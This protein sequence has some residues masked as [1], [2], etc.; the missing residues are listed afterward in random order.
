MFLLHPPRSATPL[1]SALSHHALDAALVDEGDA[2]LSMCT[3]RKRWCRVHAESSAAM[4]TTSPTRPRSEQ[5]Q[6]VAR[7]V[8][9][10]RRMEVVQALTEQKELK[11][12][13]MNM[14]RADVRVQSQERR[15]V[16][17][18][19]KRL[20][21]SLAAQ[22]SRQHQLQV[23]E[24][25]NRLAAEENTRILNRSATAQKTRD[26]NLL[27]AVTRLQNRRKF[28]ITR[29]HQAQT[30]MED[31][32]QLT[33]A[34]LQHLT[35]AEALRESRQRSV[36][37]LLARENA[38]HE[39][40]RSPD[41]A[42]LPES[43]AKAP[44]PPLPIPA[45][46]PQSRHRLP[47]STHSPH[48]VDSE[49]RPPP[50]HAS[51]STLIVPAPTTRASSPAQRSRAA[52]PGASSTVPR[53]GKSTHAVRSAKERQQFVATAVARDAQTA[54]RQYRREVHQTRSLTPSGALMQGSL[55]NDLVPSQSEAVRRHARAWQRMFGRFSDALEGSRSDSASW[56]GQRA[57]T[58]GPQQHQQQ[59]QLQLRDAESRAEEPTSVTADPLMSNES[60]PATR[61]SGARPTTQRSLQAENSGGASPHRSLADEFFGNAGSFERVVDGGAEDGEAPGSSSEATST[62]ISDLS[63]DE[64]DISDDRLRRVV[65][66][67]SSS[68][69]VN[70]GG[71]EAQATSAANP[72]LRVAE[73]PPLDR[74]VVA[75]QRWVRTV[76]LAVA[77]R[78]QVCRDRRE[79]LQAEALSEA[80]VIVRQEHAAG[81]IQR[82][83]RRH[84]SN[85]QAQCAVRIVS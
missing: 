55:S 33:L 42:S 44:I 40:T 67:S 74:A 27:K 24:E 31:V 60:R 5:Q 12:L 41:R 21:T 78:R 56:A 52:T 72:A 50:G 49:R 6:R 29:R 45:E 77:R 28:F 65:D 8:E 9:E 59:Q 1:T 20:R 11:S 10:Y 38:V 19:E 53:S 16:V 46:R 66:G 47:A 83:W 84:H 39:T 68:T 17:S 73:H 62:E 48:R 57:P 3:S 51:Y 15:D 14:Y 22:R 36:K 35:L 64:S 82:A 80:L 54:Q 58:G 69:P 26:G 2:A 63:D 37:M 13:A 76:G 30:M 61:Q 81:D 23:Q 25:L 43:P 75:L 70:E 4:P 71:E 85:S 18:R 32:R 79:C 34:E 7:A